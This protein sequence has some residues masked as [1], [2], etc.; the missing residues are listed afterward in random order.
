VTRVGRMVGEP[1]SGVPPSA[2][3]H[4]PGEGAAARLPAR[5]ER[6]ARGPW[7]P[8]TR[9]DC[10]GTGRPRRRSRHRRC[11]QVMVE[12]HRGR[13]SS[14]GRWT[15]W[16]WLCC[17]S[18]RYEAARRR[19]AALTGGRPAPL[20]HDQR[21]GWPP[22]A[23]PH[24]RGWSPTSGPTTGSSRPTG[25]TVPPRGVLSPARRTA[26]RL[27]CSRSDA[28]HG[29][30]RVGHRPRWRRARLTGVGARGRLAVCLTRR[31]HRRPAM[32]R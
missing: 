12:G 17:S 3:R 16:S 9:P 19:L 20:R 5:S 14:Q 27:G 24:D 30:H 13:H 2:Q 29:S 31:P 18:G 1:G 7:P 26:A 11:H 28:G 25:A 6:R 8:L 21:L 22:P 32:P 10:P 4:P 15:H 23:G